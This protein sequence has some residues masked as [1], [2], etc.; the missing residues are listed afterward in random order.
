MEM[1]IDMLEGQIDIEDAIAAAP[2]IMADVGNKAL[3][4]KQFVAKT[5]WPEWTVRRAIQ[6]EHL[7]V[8][9]DVRPMLITGGEMPL[10][11]N[12]W[13]RALDGELRRVSQSR[14]SF[15]EGGRQL[16]I[17][18]RDN[19]IRTY[20]L[21]LTKAGADDQVREIKRMDIQRRDG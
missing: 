10:T 19:A 17:L 15:S 13:H 2:P 1:E 21:P 5:G 9:R 7:E 14:W 6:K 3:T 8:D 18:P 11:V 4:V 12:E 16:N 20:K